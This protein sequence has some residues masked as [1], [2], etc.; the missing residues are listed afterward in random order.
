MDREVVITCHT[1]T[2]F[3]LSQSSN[4]KMGVIFFPLGKQKV[5]DYQNHSYFFLVFT[6]SPC[7]SDGW[8]NLDKHFTLLAVAFATL[9]VSLQSY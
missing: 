8:W 9:L 7:G 3:T 2:P 4:F 1:A 5:I 6:S